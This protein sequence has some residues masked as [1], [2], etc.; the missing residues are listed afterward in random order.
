MRWQ[1]KGKAPLPFKVVFA[2][3]GINLVALIGTVYAVPRWWPSRPD[4]AHWY[5]IRFK[6][7]AVFFVQPWLGKYF[8]YGFWGG[9]GLLAF[10]FLIMWLHRDDVERVD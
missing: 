10:M 2:L 5:A 3:F 6:G 4:P 9:F 1:F 8:A 7:G